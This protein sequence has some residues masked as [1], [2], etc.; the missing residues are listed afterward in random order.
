MGLHS[1]GTT[2]LALITLKQHNGW[3]RIPWLAACVRECVCVSC[4]CVCM[5][6]C[7]HANCLQ[8][9][10]GTDECVPAF[11]HVKTPNTCNSSSYLQHNTRQVLDPHFSIIYNSIAE[12]SIIHRGPRMVQHSSAYKRM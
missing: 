1:A 11:L 4:L 2:H 9:N 10:S 6:A 5:C 7:I 3:S 12:K 8:L